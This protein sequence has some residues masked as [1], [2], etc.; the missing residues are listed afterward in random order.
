MA[1][2]RRLH[3]GGKVRKDG[4]EIVD[5]HDAPHVD[6]RRN[7][8]ELSIFEDGT[9]DEVYASHVLEHFEYRLSLLPTLKEWRRVLKDGGRLYVSV[10]D[11]KVLCQMFADDTNTP[12]EKFDV[13][14]MIFGG[15]MNEHDFH[16]AGL[17]AVFLGNFLEQA[18]F[19]DISKVD[20]FGL[21]DDTSELRMKDIAISCNMIAEK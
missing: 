15:H 5:I 1:T 3:I 11:L 8:N 10:P 12:H 9:F 2:E 4:W 20:S 18:G 14:R 17:D 6:H 16:L 19:T 21:F 7:A 13:M